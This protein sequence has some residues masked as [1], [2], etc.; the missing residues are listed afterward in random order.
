MGQIKNIKL[1]IVTDIKNKTESRITDQTICCNKQGNKPWTW[2]TRCCRGRSSTS[3]HGARTGSSLRPC[4]A[5][6]RPPSGCT[7]PNG[8]LLPNI[9]H[10]TEASMITRNLSKP[11]T[12]L[13]NC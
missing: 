2:P 9:F 7:S 11:Q 13:W 5:D 6:V 12:N 1:H 4:G 3:S 8:R 10:T